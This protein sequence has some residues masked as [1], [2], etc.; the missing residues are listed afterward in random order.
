[1]HSTREPIQVRSSHDRASEVRKIDAVAFSILLLCACCFHPTL[2]HI[3]F[4][5]QPKITWKHS[6]LRRSMEDH[7]RIN[8]LEI[9]EG[10][11][12]ASL[13]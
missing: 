1:M 2:N 6:K 13:T 10:C 4:R 3:C 11:A 12:I 5:D 7:H 9:F 8:T